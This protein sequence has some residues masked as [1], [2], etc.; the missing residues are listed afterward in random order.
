MFLICV[1]IAGHNLGLFP[2]SGSVWWISVYNNDYLGAMIIAQFK[3]QQFFMPT[4]NL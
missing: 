4:L 1:L 3:Q 2:N